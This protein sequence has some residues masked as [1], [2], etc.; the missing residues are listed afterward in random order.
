MGVFINKYR[1]I[2]KINNNLYLLYAE[3]PIDKVMNVQDVKNYLGCDTAFR[4]NKTGT[5]IF[6]NEI[7]EAEILEEND[8]SVQFR[9]GE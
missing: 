7:E 9:P 8:P 4:N 2:Q 3:I 1:P 5:Y 6:G